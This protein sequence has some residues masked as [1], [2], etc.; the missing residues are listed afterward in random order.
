M[1]ARPIAS[2]APAWSNTIERSVPR[3]NTNKQK[4]QRRETT[5]KQGMKKQNRKPGNLQGNQK[6]HEQ[7]RIETRMTD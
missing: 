2:V 6:F 1:N 3:M 5:Q 4:N 7:E